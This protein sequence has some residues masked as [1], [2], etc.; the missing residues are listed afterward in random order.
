MGHVDNGVFHEIFP[1]DLKGRFYA[2]AV[3]PLDLKGR[4]YA[5]LAVKHKGEFMCCKLA[6]LNAVGGAKHAYFVC[7]S[8]CG[9]S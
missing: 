2:M 9:W 6:A 3:F 8:Y 5:T 7:T 4:F 1:L